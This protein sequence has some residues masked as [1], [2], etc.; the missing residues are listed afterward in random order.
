M[1]HSETSPRRLYLPLSKER[2]KGCK[3]I[4]GKK[5]EEKAVEGKFKWKS[6]KRALDR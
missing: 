3:L 6:S 4:E 5:D 1:M 2:E